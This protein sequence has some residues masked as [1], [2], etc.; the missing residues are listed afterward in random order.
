MA[1]RMLA[2]MTSPEVREAIDAGR[3]TIVLAFGSFEQHG[4]HLPIG[5]DAMLGD[6]IGRRVAEQLDAVL[7]PTVQVGCADHHLP[8][9]GTISVSEETLISIAVDYCRG[10]ARHGFR[11]IVLLPTHGGNFRAIGIAA[12]RCADIEGATVISAVKDFNDEV[13][14][15]GT[16]G[17]SAKYGISAAESGAHAG[18]WETSI[19]LHLT[20]D[21]VRM[22]RAVEGYVGDI[23]AAVDHVLTGGSLQE[24]APTGILGDPRRA[25]AERGE[26]YLASLT[27]M[28]LS[29][30]ERAFA[31]ASSR[32][33][34]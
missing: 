28:A 6:E 30:I 14:G 23:G 8:F 3:D 32:S 24:I 19:M 34:P 20:P 2:R 15:K 5:T 31:S 17:L 13:L 9:A 1:V 27:A 33:T 12:Q 25:A 22:D 18:E 26:P 10:L 16:V 21:L 11:R 7:G 29:G 4:G